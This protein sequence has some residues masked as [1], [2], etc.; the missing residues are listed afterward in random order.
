MSQL[1]IRYLSQQ[2]AKQFD[3]QLMSAE[4][5]FSLEQLM[6]LAGLSVAS[7]V[8]E[9]VAPPAR[10]IVCAGKGNNGGDGLVC[11]RHLSHMGYECELVCPAH[12]DFNERMQRLVLQCRQLDVPLHSRLPEL[13]D[14]AVIVDAM[15]GFGFKPPLKGVY[16]D[17]VQQM[18][19]RDRTKHTLV[20]VDVPTGWHVEQGPVDSASAL[21]PDVLVSLSAPKLCAQHFSGIH[22]LGGRF[23]PRSLAKKYDIEW[24][25]D[26]YE[27]TAQQI[28]LL[29]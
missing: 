12:T 7:A 17:L 26:A 20:S 15:L 4:Y 11:A 2:A 29:E 3:L 10:V 23:V 21:D 19:S 25:C 22:F 16:F 28:T 14:K 13:E 1:P 18:K 5:G 8:R 6:E 27:N 9:I 24:V